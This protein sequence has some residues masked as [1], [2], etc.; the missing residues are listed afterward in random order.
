MRQPAYTFATIDCP[1]RP[2]F[3]DAIADV[4][5]HPYIYEHDDNRCYSERMSQKSLVLFGLGA[6]LVGAAL[7]VLLDVPLALT[8]LFAGILFM[9]LTWIGV[10]GS[11]D[12]KA[13]EIFAKGPSL[14]PIPKFQGTVTDVT[15]SKVLLQTPL[16]MGTFLGFN[17]RFINDSP[18]R[19]AIEAVTVTVTDTDNVVFEDKY[20]SML[21]G[22][23]PLTLPTKAYERGDSGLISVTARFGGLDYDKVTTDS[24]T[25]RLT[26]SV[27]RKEHIIRV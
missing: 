16:R 3:G 14:P 4:I 8:V 1:V 19:A 5:R 12:T 20:P 11:N 18:Q 25:V 15:H 27:V 26:D 17:L 23:L 6:V 7:R 22:G 10:L 13:A 21:L 2:D 9:V 24:L